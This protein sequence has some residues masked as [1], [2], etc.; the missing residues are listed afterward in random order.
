MT[1]DWPYI[2]GWCDKHGTRPLLERIRR[3]VPD[4]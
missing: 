1:I 3:T 2:E 4:V